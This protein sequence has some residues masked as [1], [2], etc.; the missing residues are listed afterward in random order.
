MAGRLMWWWCCAVC[1]IMFQGL[2]QGVSSSF[3]SKTVASMLPVYGQ[4]MVDGNGAVYVN[5]RK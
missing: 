2:L 3:F 5:I 1:C 4:A